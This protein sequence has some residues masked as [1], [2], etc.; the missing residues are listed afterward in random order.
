MNLFYAPGLLPDNT[1]YTFGKE[2]SRHIVKVLRKKKGDRLFLTD[3]V[4]GWYEGEITKTDFKQTIVKIQDYKKRRKKAYRLHIAIAPV[5]SN[6]RFEW[7]L[8]KATEIGIDEI[9]PLWNKY[10]ERKKI[11]KNRY[12]KIIISAMK[13]SLQVYKPILNNFTK[14]NDFIKQVEDNQY[15]LIAYCKAQQNLNDVL[16]KSNN[17]KEI[18]KI[19]IVIGPEGGFSDEEL[20]IA[21]QVG[22]IPILLSNNRLRTETAGVVAV[23]NV[24]LKMDF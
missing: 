4:G 24:H 1:Q 23:S 18:D 7:F 16:K 10:S 2:E 14:W 15:K 9:T 20:N 3:G 22:F 17:D 6:D 5:K 11:N 8:E 13:Q 19:V 12:E 21:K